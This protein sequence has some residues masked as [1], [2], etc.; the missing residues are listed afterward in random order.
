MKIVGTFF[1]SIT[2]HKNYFLTYYEPQT[3]FKNN[4]VLKFCLIHMHIFLSLPNLFSLQLFKKENQ[5]PNMFGSLIFFKR[6]KNT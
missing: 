6:T 3:Y 5:L 4:V 2:K 1:K